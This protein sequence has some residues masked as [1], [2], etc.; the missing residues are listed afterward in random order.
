SSPGNVLGRK[1]CSGSTRRFRAI[2]EWDRAS[3]PAARP[4]FLVCGRTPASRGVPVDPDSRWPGQRSTWIWRSR[5]ARRVEDAPA[6]LGAVAP[7]RSKSATFEPR[8]TSW[9]RLLAVLYRSGITAPA[10]ESRW[11]SSPGRPAGLGSP[12]GGAATSQFADD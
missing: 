7:L 10:S 9:V 5:P 2:Q 1:G 11:A 6:Y 3:P 4:Q 12:V 8:P